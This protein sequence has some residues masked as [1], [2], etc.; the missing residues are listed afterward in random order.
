MVGVGVI[1]KDEDWGRCDQLLH[2]AEGYLFR[3]FS[4]PSNIFLGEVEQGMRM[5]GEVFDE[6]LVKVDEPNK[7]LNMLLVPWCW[8]FCYTRNLD[9]I[10]LHLAFQHNNSKVLY[11]PL[12][13]LAFLWFEVQLVFPEMFQHSLH[14]ILMLQQCLS[15]YEDVVCCDK[16]YVYLFYI[17]CKKERN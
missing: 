17:N 14:D 12:L 2:F 9:W 11:L 15:E 13:K 5:V 16:V 6:P 4:F 1:Q 10:H 7:G 8:P 3:I